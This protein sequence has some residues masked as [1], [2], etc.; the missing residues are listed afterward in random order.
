MTEQ[1][2][3]IR[4]IMSKRSHRRKTKGLLCS[5]RRRSTNTKQYIN[6]P[7]RQYTFMSGGSSIL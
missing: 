7:K 3:R 4:T 2:Y 1:E 6:N 5:Q